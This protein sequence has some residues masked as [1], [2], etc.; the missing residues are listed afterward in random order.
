MNFS[1][2]FCADKAHPSLA[3]AHLP[4]LVSTTF[5]LGRLSCGHGNFTAVLVRDVLSGS[6]AY[7]PF[8]PFLTHV[9]VLLLLLFSEIF[10][11]PSFP[12][13]GVLPPCSS[14]SPDLEM[15]FLIIFYKFYLLLFLPSLIIGLLRAGSLSCSSSYSQLLT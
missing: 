1:L 4:S 5:S 2:L 8:L 3:H 7:T 13:L 6:D 11:G 12:K 10:L 15:A 14:N 9:V